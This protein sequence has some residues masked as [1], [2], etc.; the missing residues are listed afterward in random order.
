MQRLYYHDAISDLR[1][2]KTTMRVM[3]FIAGF[4]GGVVVGL[5]IV[6][7]ITPQSGSELQAEVR[8]RFDGILSEG[9]R[10]AAARRAELEARLASL[11]A[12]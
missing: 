10:A 2:S 12:A 5:V 4:L 1:R 3:H 8:S 9:R 6:L 11:K 7:L